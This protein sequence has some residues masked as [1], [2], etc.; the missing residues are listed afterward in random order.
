[1]EYRSIFTWCKRME[2]F[3]AI[4]M[5]EKRI[6]NSTFFKAIKVKLNVNSSFND[7][8][9]KLQQYMHSTLTVQNNTVIS[10]QHCN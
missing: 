2:I 8:L 7:Y 1:M 10:L 4:I 5:F 3:N 9:H 6:N